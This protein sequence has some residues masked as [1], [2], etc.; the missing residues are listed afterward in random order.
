M[1]TFV[2]SPCR[3]KS[4]T[5][6]LQPEVWTYQIHLDVER[7]SRADAELRKYANV[8]FLQVRQLATQ[9]K[10]QASTASSKSIFRPRV[11]E[12]IEASEEGRL[13]SGILFSKG[14]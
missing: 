2:G 11:V 1:A 7:E 4:E 12:R 13:R 3:Q 14:Q 8:A 5:L 9:V 6:D 10:A